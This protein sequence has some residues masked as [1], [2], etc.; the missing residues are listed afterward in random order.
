MIENIKKGKQSCCPLFMLIVVFQNIVVMPNEQLYTVQ[1]INCIFE[2]IVRPQVE[3]GLSVDGLGQMLIKEFGKFV[4]VERGGIGVHTY[5]L[6][7]PVT[8]FYPS[9]IDIESLETVSLCY[10]LCSG[11]NRRVFVHKRD[12]I[13]RLL[14]CWRL[15][16]KVTCNGNVACRLVIVY[17]S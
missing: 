15:V 10:T 4:V 11:K 6:R 7:L 17:V 8:P 13:F 3:F 2:T 14:S 9:H 12:K 5:E 1:S 16:G